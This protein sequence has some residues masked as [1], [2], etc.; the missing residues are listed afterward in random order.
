MCHRLLI[1]HNAHFSKNIMIDGDTLELCHELSG[2]N[3]H[4][5]IELPATSHQ[6]TLVFRRSSFVKTPAT[7]HRP[8]SIVNGPPATSHQPSS[9]AHH[10]SRPPPPPDPARA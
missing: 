6:P 7:V 4:L 9:I 2:R 10:P 1:G 5:V 8:P 3:G